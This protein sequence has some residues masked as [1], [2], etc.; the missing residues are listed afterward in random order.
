MINRFI[1]KIKQKLLKEFEAN[2]RPVVDRSVREAF[3]R[4]RTLSQGATGNN[5][6][7]SR[8]PNQFRRVNDFL[9]RYQYVMQSGIGAITIVIG[10]YGLHLAQLSYNAQLESNQLSRDVTGIK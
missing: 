4:H 2:I 5:I 1:S 6:A 3:E 10:G 8:N 7:H 9:N